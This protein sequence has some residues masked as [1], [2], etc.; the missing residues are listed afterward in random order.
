[1]SG[2]SNFLPRHT[3]APRYRPGERLDDAGELTVRGATL[4]RDFEGEQLWITEGTIT[5]GGKVLDNECPVALEVD[6]A[7]EVRLAGHEGSLTV[8]GTGFRIET[9]GEARFVEVFIG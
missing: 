3:T 7:V 4:V 2:S 8:T 6:D 9:T 5:V 1:M